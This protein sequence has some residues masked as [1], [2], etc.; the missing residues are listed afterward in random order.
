MRTKIF[1]NLI[2]EKI[3]LS[4]LSFSS[5]IISII[6]KPPHIPNAIDDIAIE[7]QMVEICIARNS[8]INCLKYLKTVFCQIIS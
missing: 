2:S 4:N 7:K 8:K 6:H 1:T 5:Y 3:F